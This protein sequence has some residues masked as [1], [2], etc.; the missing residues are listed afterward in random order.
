MAYYAFKHDNMAQ[1]WLVK[2]KSVNLA[3]GLTRS[4]RICIA[5]QNIN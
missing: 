2:V 1:H 3:I 5:E 4:I